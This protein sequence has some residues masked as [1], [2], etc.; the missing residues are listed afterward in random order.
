MADV[1]VVNDK[2]DTKRITRVPERQL[3]ALAKRGWRK[4]TDDDLQGLS[5]PELQATAAEQGVRVP[6]GATKADLA[7]AITKSD[8]QSQE[9]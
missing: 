6:A 8:D 9:A 5:K 3:V 4:A 2:S 7:A 1:L